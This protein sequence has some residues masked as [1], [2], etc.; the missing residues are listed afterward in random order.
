MTGTATC[1]V[2]GR[3]YALS[4]FSTAL[5]PRGR[6]HYFI[7]LSDRP[8]AMIWVYAAL[9]MRTEGVRPP[10]RGER[11]MKEMLWNGVVPTFEALWVLGCSR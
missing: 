6:C 3:M 8:M 4:D 10:D 9:S 11:K 5:A 7:N 2:E 1:V